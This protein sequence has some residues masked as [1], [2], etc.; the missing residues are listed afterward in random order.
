MEDLVLTQ[1]R[2]Q[3]HLYLLREHKVNRYGD[4]DGHTLNSSL[5]VMSTVVNVMGGSLS[6]LLL[7]KFSWKHLCAVMNGFVVFA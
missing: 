7:E 4:S 3:D 6:V 2:D 1:A 5:L